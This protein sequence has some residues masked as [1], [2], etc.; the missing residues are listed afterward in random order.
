MHIN[1]RGVSILISAVAVLLVYFFV[2]AGSI[3]AALE[4]FNPGLIIIIFLLYALGQVMSAVKWRCIF[5]EIGIDVGLQAAVNAYFMGMFVNVAGLGTLGGDGARALAI[6]PEKGKHLR[7]LASVAID[8][9]HGLLILSLIGA[10]GAAFYPP[11]T[12]GRYGRQAAILFIFGV[13][14]LL[15]ASPIVLRYLVQREFIPSKFRIGIGALVNASRKSLLWI[16]FL[17]AMF[18][19]LQIFIHCLIAYS[20]DLQLPVLYWLSV[21]PLVNIIGSLPISFNGLGVREF[22]YVFFLT[23][24]GVPE[25]GAVLVASIWFATV[26]GVG[27][28]GGAIVRFGRAAA[29][30]KKSETVYKK[31]ACFLT[32][33]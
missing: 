23:P 29:E 21:V 4:R 8:R 3:L 24:M 31:E 18:H 11:Q 12:L 2:G 17:S 20:L 22:L 15:A 14:V 26:I 33:S 27:L 19:L 13:V 25:E 30:N 1:K 10:V 6:R 32:E 9:L 7:A 16:S 28:L 5:K